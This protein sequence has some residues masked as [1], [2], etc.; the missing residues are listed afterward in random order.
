MSGTVKFEG[1]QEE[2]DALVKKNNADAL[3]KQDAFLERLINEEKELGEKIA[4]LEA[5]LKSD[6]FKGI[7]NVQRGLL[8]IQLIAMATYSQILDERLWRL[9]SSESVS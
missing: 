3:E 6:A 9:S 5:F 2:W 4:K 1:T 7:D 8:K